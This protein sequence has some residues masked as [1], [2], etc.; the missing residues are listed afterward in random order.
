M[1]ICKD[2]PC[3]DVVHERYTLPKVPGNT[4]NIKVIL[5]SEGV[6]ENPDDYYYSNGGLYGQT[7]LD[8]FKNAGLEVGSL[9]ELLELG[10]YFTTAIKCCKQQYL[11][12]AKTV[13]SCSQIL[14]KEL[15]LFNNA[16]V[17]LLM[18]DV[19]IKSLNY[20]S[21]RLYN[22]ICVP[23]ES[24]YKIR[25]NEYRFGNMMVIPS[26]LQAGKAY[27]IETSKRK[28][29]T[30]DIRSALEFANII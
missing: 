18:G 2:F 30:D 12:S 13:K 19:A 29:L 25:G 24:T 6:P 8:A 17:L 1:L 22:K 4:G 5:I 27:F 9:D 10:I 26:Y 11:V 16:R 15:E 20:I 7:T 14:E 3:E 21:K 28:M 23:K